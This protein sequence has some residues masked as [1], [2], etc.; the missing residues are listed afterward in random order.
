MLIYLFILIIIKLSIFISS[1]IEGE[2]NCL[3]CNPITNLCYKCATDFYI[4]NDKG[5]CNIS[6]KCKVGFN[7]CLQ[8]QENN[9]NNICKICEKGYYPDGSGGCSYTKNCLISK[10]GICTLCNE[11]Y[12]LIGKEVTFCKSLLSE[13]LKSCK[14]INTLNGFCLNCTEGFYLNN[15]DLKCSKTE[16]CSESKYG[17]C[18]KCNKGF[19][20]NKKEEK[21]IIQNNSFI[22]C[23]ISIL[24]EKCDICDDNY[25]FD[26]EGI[27]ISMNY[28]SLGDKKRNICKECNEGYF[29]SEFKDSCTNEQNCYEGDKDLGICLKCRQGFYLDYKDGKCKLNTENDEFKY[30]Q[31]SDNNLCKNCLYGYYLSEDLKCSLAKNCAEVYN[32]QCTL[33]INNYY[34]GLDNKCSNVENCIYSNYF[35]ECLEC[36]DNYYYNKKNFKCE[37]SRG[38]FKGC[39]YGHSDWKCLSCKY[40][41]YLNQNDSL[42]YNNNE[43]GPFYKCALT[44]FNGEYCAKC[45][46]NYNLGEK[47][48][49]C[50]LLKG[51]K[52][53]NNEN[54]CI[55]CNEDYCLDVNLGT[56]EYNFEIINKE[57]KFYFRCNKTNKEG[58]KCEICDNGFVLNNNGLCMDINNCE[59]KDEDGNCKKCKINE[60]GYFCLNKDFGCIETYFDDCLE[61]GDILDFDKCTKCIDGY[62]IG[63]YDLCYEIE[64]NYFIKKNIN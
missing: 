48:H 7:N 22:N 1:C 3:K 36:K 5:G 24:G 4:P 57:K 47:D 38:I 63:E 30:C 43:E 46:D 58:D 31:I 41:F 51:C 14:N 26:E 10:N 28:C 62:E 16:N 19:Y 2:N 49:K 20:L 33:C 60:N 44:D 9:N 21:C 35:E 6:S 64:E 42:C 52:L 18:K 8:C 59:E 39:K 40:N 15:I 56:C 29:L 34:L 61:C 13:D 37:I 11:H 54:K 25:Y 17:I 27:C 23:K 32:G 50:T 53:V 55:E 12:I 45:I